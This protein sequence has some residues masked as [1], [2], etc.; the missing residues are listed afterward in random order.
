MWHAVSCKGCAFL[1]PSELD[2]PVHQPHPPMNLRHYSVA[3]AFLLSSLAASA[4]PIAIAGTEGYKVYVGSAND[5][6]ATYEGNSAAYSNDLYLQGF[7]F[8]FNNHGSAVGSTVNLGS[9]AVGTEL[10][11]RLHVNNTGY[12]Y[13]TGDAAL[14]PDGQ[15]HARVQDG[16]MTDTTLVSFED[17][18]NGPFAFNDLSFSFTN[19]RGA[20]VPPS[21]PDTLPTAGALLLALAAMAAARRRA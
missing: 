12:S 9:Y 19:T 16:W 20:Q 10:V 17:L 8:V 7:G 11:F 21:V 2:H 4:F 3:A 13:Y 6:I 14:N 18:Y 5:I 15:F 1:F